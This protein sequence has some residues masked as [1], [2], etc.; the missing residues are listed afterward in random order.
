MI[1]KRS[2]I[3]A[4]AVL[5]Q[6]GAA[7]A[8]SGEPREV[9]AHGAWRVFVHGD[10]AAKTCFMASPPERSQGA[11]GRRRG[12]VALYVANRPAAGAKNE[13]SVTIGYPFRPDSAT[14][15]VGGR[16]YPMFTEG[17][18]AWSDNQDAALVAEMRR[19]LTLSVKATSSAGTDTLDTFSLRGFSRAHDALNAQCP[20]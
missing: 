8:Q 7:I 11:E 14:I 1:D 5:A 6:T 10:G 4:L 12:P 2:L 9:A 3:V 17:E 20:V 16:T 15:E 18:T 19:K 13:V